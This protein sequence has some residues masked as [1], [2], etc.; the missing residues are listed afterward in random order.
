MA[1][2]LTNSNIKGNCDLKC[3]YNFNYG[4]SNSIATNMGNSIQIS[5]EDS[6]IPPVT[7]NNIK[8][9]VS[10]I[11]I[12]YPSAILYNNSQAYGNII[13]EHTSLKDKGI[14]QV[15]IPLVTSSS[16]STAS[17]L[18]SQIIQSVATTAPNTK[19]NVN[20]NIPNFTLQNIVP[21]GPYYTTSL[22]N[23]VTAI[24]Y[25]LDYAIGISNTTCETLSTIISSG[26]V[27][28][29]SSNSNYS[30]F[31]NSKGPNNQITGNEEIYISC[32]PTGNSE[33]DTAVSFEKQK[34]ETTLINWSTLSQ[35]P[36]FII[37]VYICVFIILLY[38]LS[39]AINMLSSTSIKL[40]FFG[41]KNKTAVK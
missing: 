15:I 4:N 22:S 26:P 29:S 9:N 10:V 21:K 39:M 19:E 12:S 8:Y 35:N 38:L 20:L 31:Y 36:F 2:N 5:Y 41:S 33:E 16:T 24:M 17:S 23:G 32:Q 34:N 40:P 14:L 27:T 18:I 6:G 1:I 7:Y 3:D 28:T 11:Q 13:I 37:F 25:D 30:I